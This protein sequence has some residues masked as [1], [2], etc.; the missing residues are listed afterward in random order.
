MTKVNGKFETPL[1]HFGL[2]SEWEVENSRNIRILLNPYF[3]DKHYPTQ[4]LFKDN[5]AEKLDM[6]LDISLT[7]MVPAG[8]RSAGQDDTYTLAVTLKEEPKYAY[9]LGLKFSEKKLRL[10]LR[11]QEL[12]FGALTAIVR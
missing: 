6:V 2:E 1:G 5:S 9:K 8:M 3:G 11:D 7:G 4:V 12:S 10:T